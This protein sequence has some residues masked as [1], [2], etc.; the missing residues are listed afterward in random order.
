MKTTLKWAAISVAA[1]LTPLVVAAPPA[2][3]TPSCVAQST[4]AEHELYGTSW[5]HEQ[6]AFL[7]SHPEVLREFGFR[8]LG[9]LAKYAASQ[10]PNACPADL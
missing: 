9:Q 4:Q 7:A 8:N 3:A 10:D 5:G 1:V 2:A 6:I